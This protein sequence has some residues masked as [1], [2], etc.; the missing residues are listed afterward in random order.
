MDPEWRSRLGLP[1]P[2]PRPLAEHGWLCRIA[3]G[4]DPLV[5]HRCRLHHV[6]TPVLLMVSLMEE[7]EVKCF[8]PGPRP[9]IWAGGREATGLGTIFIL[10]NGAQQ[11]SARSNGARQALSYVKAEMA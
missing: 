4:L 3:A 6:W 10:F 2:P 1:N 8:T 11:Y 5:W 7:V 9:G